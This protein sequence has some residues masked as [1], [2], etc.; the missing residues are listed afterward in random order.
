MQ[1]CRREAGTSARQPG[2]ESPE[3]HGGTIA[4]SGEEAEEAEEAEAEADNTGGL[5]EERVQA[6]GVI[7]RG[8][9]GIREQ[10]G[11]EGRY[12]HWYGRPAPRR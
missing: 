2:A 7:E 11:R 6:T 4:G 8:S 12:E 3:R 5:L 10:G 9:R 1:P